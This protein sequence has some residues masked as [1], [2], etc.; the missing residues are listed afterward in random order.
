MTMML[1]L[2]S[3]EHLTETL[4]ISMSIAG[5]NVV[6]DVAKSA[7][8]GF[9]AATLLAVSPVADAKVILQQPEVK[10]FVKGTTPPPAQKSSSPAKTK[11]RKN[12]NAGDPDGFDFKSLALPLSVA[13]VV[14]AGVA[15]NALDPGFAEFME[16]ASTKDS[17]PFAGYETGLKD[18]PFFGGNGD[19]P[20]S[21]SGGTA[22]KTTKKTLK[23]GLF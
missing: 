12:E 1:L 7:L 17:R 21:T 2:L 13:G 10:N 20:R 18:T 4:S 9:A 19:I 15:L 3:L 6:A 14:G 16:E 5:D 8:A 23:G 22:R 11:E